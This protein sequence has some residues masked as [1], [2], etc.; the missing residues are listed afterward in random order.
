MKGS[1][2]NHVQ[3]FDELVGDLSESIRNIS[4]PMAVGAMLYS[5][6]QEKKSSNLVIRDINAKFDQMIQKLEE[7]SEKIGKISDTFSKSDANDV[8]L[9]ERDQEVLDFI[10]ESERVCADDVQGK[11]QY[12]GRNAASARLSKLFKEQKVK[13]I[14]VGRKVYYTIKSG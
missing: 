1:I 2:N 6:A 9:S 11:F 3:E 4:D 7:I 8:E 14:Y 13:K 5:I 12:R 10:K